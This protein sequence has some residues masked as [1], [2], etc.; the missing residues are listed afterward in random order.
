[1]F[2]FAPA[3]LRRPFGQCRRDINPRQR[4]GTGSNRISPRENMAGQFFKMRSLCRQ[5]MS[6]CL[7]DPQCLFMQFG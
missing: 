5:C 1:M 2:S 6:R 3:P 4:I 7:S